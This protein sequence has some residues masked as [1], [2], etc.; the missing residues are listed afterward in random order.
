LS[1]IRGRKGF[2]TP[3]QKDLQ[4]YLEQG[5]KSVSRMK[6]GK[7][8]LFIRPKRSVSIKVISIIAL[9]VVSSTLFITSSL[10]T[11]FISNDTENDT[12]GINPSAT[13][14]SLSTSTSTTTTTTI[15]EPIPNLEVSIQ[16]I[17]DLIDE[18]VPPNRSLITPEI[19]NGTIN[20]SSI[21]NTSEVFD[22]VWSLSQ[23][24]KNSERW[25]LGREL[26]FDVFHI[27]NQ[28]NLLTEPL[29]YQ[30]RAL[31]SLI[32]YPATEIPLETEDLEIFENLT[33]AL[34]LNISS[35]FNSTTGTFFSEKNDS[36]I[37]MPNYLTLLNILTKKNHHPNLN[38][39][40]STTFLVN[41]ILDFLYNLILTN[42]GLPD[43]IHPNLTY[44]SPIYHSSYQNELIITLKTVSTEITSTNIL[45]I[46]ISRLREFIEN[47][48]LQQDWSVGFYYNQTSNNLNKEMRLIDQILYIRA[49]V[50]L[51][52]L[53]FAKFSI[54]SL[55]ENFI[56]SNASFYT[57]INN[58][59]QQTLMDQI[60]LLLTFEEFIELESQVMTTQTHTTGT[61]QTTA[62][63]SSWTIGIFLLALLI[64][65]I[66]R[67]VYAKREN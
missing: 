36:K 23:F 45:E 15:E 39:S 12:S 42:N 10:L 61:T 51:E 67:R 57:S 11:V 16:E 22:I 56:D 32:S 48:F 43:E 31:R 53:N 18:M 25:I 44:I 55:L 2:E 38:I 19:I 52:R 35:Q 58:S 1:D 64:I 40:E 3:S 49:N 59:D 37:F 29:D 7:R 41:S 6:A 47:Y 14:T 24:D 63:A 54:E 33:N 8:P 60:I 17:E 30:L 5:T 27:W 9:I 66:R 26:C 13:T 46:L 28:S 20:S 4:N 62:S 21:I 34:W 50:K 65:Q